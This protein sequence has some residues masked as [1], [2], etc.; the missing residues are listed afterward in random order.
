WKEGQ[1][2]K[3][4]DAGAVD[5]ERTDRLLLPM[6]NTCV[7][8]LRQGVIDDPE[9]LDGAMI[10]GTGFAPFRGGPL[11]YARSRGIAEIVA[12]LEKLA[13]HHGERFKPDPDWQKLSSA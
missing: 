6:L 10:F 2:R 8:C 3:K 12:T 4:E 11:H 9:L 1:P 7:A 5:P 13:E